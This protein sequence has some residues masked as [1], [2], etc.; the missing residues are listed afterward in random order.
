MKFGGREVKISK[1]VT[2]CVPMEMAAK[3][4]QPD[5]FCPTNST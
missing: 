5:L 4:Y 2:F 1:L 3:Y